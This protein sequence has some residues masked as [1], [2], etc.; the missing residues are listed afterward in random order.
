MAIARAQL[1]DVSL[2]RWYKGKALQTLGYR[3]NYLAQSGYGRPSQTSR[4]KTVRV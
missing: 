1:V 3:L 4:Q 2:T